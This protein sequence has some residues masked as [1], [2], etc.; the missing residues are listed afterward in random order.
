MAIVVVFFAVYFLLLRFPLFQ[1]TVMPETIVDRWIGFQPAA[2]WLYVSLWAYVQ[3]PAA[4]LLRRPEVA[5]YGKAIALLSLAGFVIFIA[6]PTRLDSASFDLA[7]HSAFRGLKTIDASGNA[8][9]SLHVA[10]AIFSAASI[11][12]SLR[13]VFAPTWTRCL[14]NLW[15]IGIVYSTLATRQHVFLDVVA[16]TALGAIAALLYL[17]RR[18]RIAPEASAL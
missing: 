2:F 5:L 12:Q 8:C 1:P 4:L 9:P 14:N 3:I 6:W 17:K 11:N 15:C 16:G 13:E 18:A 10:F 7:H